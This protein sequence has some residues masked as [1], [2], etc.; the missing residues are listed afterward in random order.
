MKTGKTWKAVLMVCLMVMW[1]PMTA[2]AETE[3]SIE[4]TK[5]YQGMNQSF[6]Q[7]YEPE[8]KK[9]RMKLVVPFFSSKAMEE[10]KIVV[11]VEFDQTKESP[12]YYKNYRKEVKRSKGNLFLFNCSLQMKKDRKNGQ[13]PLYLR[14]MGK[15]KGG[16]AVSEVFTIYVEITDGTAAVTEETKNPEMEG[17]TQFSPGQEMPVPEPPVTEL[18]E[19]EESGGE[20][21]VHQPRVLLDTADLKNQKLEA[22]TDITSAITA[23]N[24]SDTMAMK[25]VK[26]T[27]SSENTGILFEK[28][29]WYFD[30]IS[31]GASVLLD[32]QISLDKKAFGSIPVQVQFEYDDTKGNSYTSGENFALSV[33][34]PSVVSLSNISFPQ[35]VYEADT[36][37]LTLQVQNA[38]LTPVY[39][40]KITFAGTGLFAV[41]ELFLGTIGAGEAAEGEIP[42]YAGTLNMEEGETEN[43]QKEAYG[44][45]S[46][47]LMFSYEDETGE[48]H[49]EELEVN[50]E[51]LKPVNLELHVEEKEPETNQW[52][53]TIAVSG[54]L[55]LLLGIIWMFKR[56]QYYK[57]RMELHETP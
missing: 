45:T 54:G 55:V 1:I 23:K 33:T 29:A 11:S 46:G 36:N 19:G 42:V 9:N 20:P 52:W 2:L 10:N 56:M 49:Q 16:E 26:I 32:S 31:P 43:Q 35:T 48:I 24:C 37:P 34:A 14:V 41:S 27:I 15:T 25:N 44:K 38:G 5:A 51:I 4:N 13:Y 12:I 7:G 50:T 3:I 39:N 40:A 30:K 6:A 18:P 8:I 57:K 47:K 28:S 21:V 22:G 53:I 17:D